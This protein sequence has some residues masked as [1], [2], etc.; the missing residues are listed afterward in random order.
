M[1]A[2]KTT[3]RT[4]K[5]LEI[6]Y[7]QPFDFDRYDAVDDEEVVTVTMMMTTTMKPFEVFALLV[8]FY[9]PFWNGLKPSSVY[10]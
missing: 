10:V 6:F 5:D 2:L 4:F 1:A 9:T 8:N 3:K 7:P